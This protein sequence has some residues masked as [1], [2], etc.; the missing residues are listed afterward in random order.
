V[1]WLLKHLCKLDFRVTGT[2]NIPSSSAVVYLKHSSAWETLAELVVFPEQAWVLKKEIRW[3]PFVGT[4]VVALNSIAIDRKS[5]HKAVRQVIEQGKQRLKSGYFVMIF[6]EGTRVPNGESRR[7]G[8]SGALLAIEAGVPLIPVSH[9]AGYFWPRRSWIKW[10]GTIDMVIGTPISTSGKTAQQVNEEA[11]TWIESTL[12][13]LPGA[14]QQGKP[15][16]E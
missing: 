3:I 5:G 11:R 10:P 15:G 9:N 7:Y 14:R 12:E 1:M 2:E 16:P 6:P 13:S 4:G 8:A